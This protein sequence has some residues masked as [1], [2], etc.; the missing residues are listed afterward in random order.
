M[1]RTTRLHVVQNVVGVKGYLF[2]KENDQ[3]SE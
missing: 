1:T 3:V 2:D